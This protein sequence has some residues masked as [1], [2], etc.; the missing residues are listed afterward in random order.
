MFDM[1]ETVWAT[2]NFKSE[3]QY[4]SCFPYPF[5]HP[6]LLTTYTPHHKHVTWKKKVAPAAS[7]LSSEKNGAGSCQPSTW[8]EFLWKK[9]WRRQRTATRQVESRRRGKVP[10]TMSEYPRCWERIPP[11]LL[12]SH[13][14]RA[15][16][17]AQ[18]KSIDEKLSKK[19]S[20][21]HLKNTQA[22][23]FS[24]SSLESSPKRGGKVGKREEEER[25]QKRERFSWEESESFSSASSEPAQRLPDISKTLLLS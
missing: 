15:L 16:F 1:I 25:K 5:A 6:N 10:N 22:S 12:I 3:I 18:R 9:I 2:T 19:S 23:N 24:T 13:S 14:T 21:F 7:Q 8:A 20:S 11:L 17:T 4:L